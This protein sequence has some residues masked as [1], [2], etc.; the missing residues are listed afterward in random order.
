MR[1]HDIGIAV[2]HRQIEQIFVLRGILKSMVGFRLAQLLSPNSPIATQ[3]PQIEG[4]PKLPR[5]IT[6]KRWQME[7]HFELVG[8]AKS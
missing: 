6:A 8:V 2:K 3:I 1:G 4:L 7:R 5:Q